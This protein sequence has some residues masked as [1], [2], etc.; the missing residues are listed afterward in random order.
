MN[1]LKD[2][3]VALTFLTR[4]GR[5]HITTSEAISKSMPMYPMVGLLLGL[6][7]AL[8]SRLPLSPWV[9]AW[10]LTGLNIYLTRGLHW[11]GW[12]DLWDGWGSGAT[13]ERFW[14]IVKDSHIGAFGTMGLILGLG[15]QTALFEAAVSRDAW[16][17]LILAPVFGRFSC[18]VLARMSQNLS[19]PGLGQ[20]AVQGATRSALI[21]GGCTTLLPALALAPSHLAATLATTVAVLAAL[22]ALGRKQGGVNGDFLGA[23]IIAGEICVLLPLSLPIW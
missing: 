3:L 17:A 18:L 22:L 1:P 6:I 15:L 8:C 21:V 5:A 2:F 4:L 9:L 13:G 23:A 20:N 10:I 12:A 16:S 19:R 11:D 14:T 7:L